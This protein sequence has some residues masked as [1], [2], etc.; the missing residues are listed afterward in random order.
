MSGMHLLPVYYTTNNLKNEKKK[1]NPAKYEAE[2][3]QHNKFLKRL[4]SPV[5]T[6]EE[7]IDYC[8]GKYTSKSE[9]C[10]GSTSVSKTESRGSTPCSDAIPSVGNG[11]GNAYR[12]EIPVYT[13]SAVIGQAYN[14]GGLQVLSAK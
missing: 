3:R 5:M 9:K 4:R 11:I 13:G 6:L 12:K 1:I 2:W 8:H 14:K 7:Y 10:Y